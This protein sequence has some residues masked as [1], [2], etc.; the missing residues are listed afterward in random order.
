VINNCPRAICLPVC[1]LCLTIFEVADIHEQCINIKLCFKLGKTFTETHEMMKSIYVD[2]CMRRTR[3]YEWF[4][5]FKGGQQSTHDDP[6]L[7]WL[8]TSCDNAHVAQVH[9]IVHSNRCL[10]VWKIAEECSISIGSCHD[11]LTTELEMHWVVSKFVPRLLT[12]DRR[13][14]CVAICQELLDHASEDE[15]FLKR[16]AYNW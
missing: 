2:Q 9:E 3:C 5:R 11:I 1:R 12:Q 15:N 13:D 6:C 14:S 8:S 4:K 16:I 7:G 10:T